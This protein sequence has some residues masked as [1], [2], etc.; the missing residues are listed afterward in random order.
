MN[1]FTLNGQDV[2]CLKS[3]KFTWIF[4]FSV[5]L[6]ACCICGRRDEWADRHKNEWIDGWIL[7]RIFRLLLVFNCHS[8]CC[9]FCCYYFSICICGY[10]F[11]LFRLKCVYLTFIYTKQKN[12]HK[13]LQLNNEIIRKWRKKI[14][15]NMSTISLRRFYIQSTH[16][17]KI[18]WI[19]LLLLSEVPFPF[20]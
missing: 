3:L 1:G 14:R 20:C 2:E 18:L 12:S 10:L 11:G 9:Y 8:C 6:S 13:N 5:C 16:L 4:R 7:C 19:L 15:N 17:N